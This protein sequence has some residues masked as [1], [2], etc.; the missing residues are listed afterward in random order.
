MLVVKERFFTCQWPIVTQSLWARI[1][2]IQAISLLWL[3]RRFDHQRRAA[4]IL[5]SSTLPG[6]LRWFKQRVFHL[7]WTFSFAKS[8][9]GS[10]CAESGFI[11]S[12]LVFCI[13][14]LYLQKGF[15]L[16]E[17]RSHV[18]CKILSFSK[19]CFRIGFF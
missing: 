10:L 18:T 13:F 5:Y 4:L 7:H 2:P 11:E 3:L 9:K 14:A 12:A 8:S 16:L 17:W 1:S 15:G 6:L 19:F